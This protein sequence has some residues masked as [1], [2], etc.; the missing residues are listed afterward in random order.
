M[1]E[2]RLIL[3]TCGVLLLTLAAPAKAA[4]KEA[5][6]SVSAAIKSYREGDFEKAQELLAEAELKCPECPE[7]AYDRGLASYRQRDFG[8]A[9]AFFSSALQTRDLGLEAKAK[10]NLGNVSFSEALEKVSDLEEAIESART[11]IFHYRDAL[12]LDPDDVDA[13]TNIEI[14]Q[15]L[16]KDLLDKQKQEQ[17]KQD[18]ACDNP[19]DQDQ[20][21]KD[22][23]NQ[24]QE[25]QDRENQ[26]RENQDSQDDQQKQNGDKQKGEDEEKKEKEGQ[27]GDKKKKQDGQ[28]DEN[29]DQQNE[30]RP[31]DEQ[32]QAQ[33]QDVKASQRK[34]TKEEFAQLMQAV[35]DKEAQRRKENK[36]RMRVRQAPVSKDW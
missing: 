29:K 24:D 11:A 6:R 10:Y 7:I 2:A 30:A 4:D 32:Q 15:L 8:A 35:R 1:L 28:S 27:E 22:Q 17:E 18:Q 13:R 14:A 20:Q 21:N 19:Q 33:P 12:E 3:P 9:R 31:N 25:N 26:D 23:E 34:L 16:I 5:A 36:R